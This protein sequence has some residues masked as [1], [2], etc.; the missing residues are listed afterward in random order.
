MLLKT[1]VSLADVSSLPLSVGSAGGL[2]QKTE[3]EADMEVSTTILTEAPAEVQTEV[4]GEVP[5]VIQTDT[6]GGAQA[7]ANNV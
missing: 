1:D 6:P 5:V 4:P 2:A 3:Q 7:K